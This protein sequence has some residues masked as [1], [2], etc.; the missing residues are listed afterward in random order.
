MTVDHATVETNDSIAVLRCD[1]GFSI[2]GDAE[3]NVTCSDDGRWSRNINACL[4]EIYFLK[5]FCYV[6]S[7]KVME[8]PNA[9]GH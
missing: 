5:S 2:D 1:E 6:E 3:F 7:A 9:G 8:H 4:S